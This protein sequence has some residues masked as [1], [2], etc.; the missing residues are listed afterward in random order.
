M[1]ASKI[2]LGILLII[3]FSLP[4]VSAQE[5]LY[6]G[7]NKIQY[8]DFD[9]H[10]IQTEHFDIYFDGGGD[11]LGKFSAQ[12]LEDAYLT[13]KEELR[14]SLNKRVPII[15]YNSHNEF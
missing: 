12:V 14:Y 5:D 15:I 4:Q 9:W 2:K 11:K 10:Y 1:S 13:V 6:F 7:K 3:L 8:K